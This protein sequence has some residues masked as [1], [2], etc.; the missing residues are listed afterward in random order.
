MEAHEIILNLQIAALLNAITRR[1]WIRKKL[2]SLLAAVIT[3]KL[4]YSSVKDP[5]KRRNI[6]HYVQF[7]TGMRLNLRVLETRLEH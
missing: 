5:D 6:T 7:M 4:V 2:Y 3:P 1:I